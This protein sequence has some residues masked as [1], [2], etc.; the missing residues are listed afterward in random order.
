MLWSRQNLGRYWDWDPKEI[1]GL[2]ASAWLVAWVVIGVALAAALWWSYFDG[3]DERAEHAMR[4]ASGADRA[5]LAVQAY[6]YAHLFMIGG[7]IM[8]AAGVHE[9]V[10]HLEQPEPASAWLISV[11]VAVYLLGAGVF[12]WLLHI[13]PAWQRFVAGGLALGTMP[14]GEWSGSFSSWRSWSWCS[15][16]CS[17]WSIG[18]S[19]C[20]AGC[21]ARYTARQ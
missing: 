15:R 7:I 2:C 1:G 4:Q 8:A 19:P 6:Y 21:T 16:G 12:R 18:S 3:D 9:A 14:V 13:G 11:G 10:G 20:T 5:R 17:W